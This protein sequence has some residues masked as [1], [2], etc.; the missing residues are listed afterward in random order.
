MQTITGIGG[1][2]SLPAGDR[3]RA[4][5]VNLFYNRFNV[6]HS[7][8]LNPDPPLSSP[9]PDHDICSAPPVS[10]VPSFTV[11]EVS[12]ELRKLQPNKGPGPE[13]VSPHLLKVCAEQLESPLQT[14]Y[15]ISLISGRVPGKRLVLFLWPNK[16]GQLRQV[17]HVQDP[18]A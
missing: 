6:P 15:N 4:N 3:E 12:A 9:S 1:K 11:D 13:G 14:L 17:Q 8:P 5:D 2:R 16:Q 18:L 7:N 10:P